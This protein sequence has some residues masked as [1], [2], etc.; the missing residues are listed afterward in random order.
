[1][2]VEARS[3]N[4]AQGWPESGALINGAYP[5]LT[6]LHGSDRSAVFTTEVRARDVAVGAIKLVRAA[7]VLTDLQLR[8]WRTATARSHPH[9]LQLFDSGQ[10]QLAGQGYLFV[11]MEYADQTLAQLLGKR[12][13]TADEAREMLPPALDA[14]AFLHRKNLVQGQLKPA[15]FMVVGDQLKLASDTVR[16]AGEPRA[17]RVPASLYDPPEAQHGRATPAG[18][19]WGLGVTLV[20]ALTQSLPWPDVTSRSTSLPPSLPPAFV[21]VVQRCLSHEP[22]A[23]PTVAELN[24]EFLRA[25]A[26]PVVPT[27]RPAA[28]ETGPAT[29]QQSLRVRRGGTGLT[30]AAVTAL[31]VLGWA[32]LRVFHGH[33]DAQPAPDVAVVSAPPPASPAASPPAAPLHAVATAQPAAPGPRSSAKPSRPPAGRIAAR[34]PALSAELP[35]DAVPSVRHAQT[36]A[37]PRTALNTIRGRIK[38]GVLVMVDGQGNVFDAL[39]ENPGPSSYFA[40]QAKDA[41]KQWKFVPASEQDSRQYLLGFE[42]TRAGATVHATPRS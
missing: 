26:A 42:F 18:D 37:I 31:F 1:M 38:I 7:P 28:R 11:V 27:A 15:N 32:A 6:M 20:E 23:R 33:A 19:V 16:P 4:V 40:R 2:G 30:A 10:C 5:L 29:P 12:A 9:L 3:E 24:A 41:A 21:D 34:A 17:S 13:L 25:P 35:A 22:T 14:L 39:L 8:H 36:P